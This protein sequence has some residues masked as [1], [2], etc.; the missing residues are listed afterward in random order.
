MKKIILSAIFILAFGF[1]VY[2]QKINIPFELMGDDDGNVT[3][4]PSVATTT[5]IPAPQKPDG[6]TTA[7]S[8]SIKYK[9]G[10]YTG[11][12]ADAYYGKIQVKAIIQNGKIT[13]VQFLDS[14][15]SLPN[16]LVVN[17]KARPIL[18]SEAIKAQS[19]EVN[20]ATGATFSSK[21]F[22][23]SLA[24]ALAQAKI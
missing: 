18:A 12:S 1:Y 20:G 11:V 15:N 19:A 23:E 10:E 3:E 13:D 9:D 14:P 16:S 7:P 21:A 17:E 22:K 2:A 24:S 6:G 5:D 4:A 8:S